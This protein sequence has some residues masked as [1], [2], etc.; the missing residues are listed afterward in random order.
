MA[1][2]ALR[3]AKKGKDMSVCSLYMKMQHVLVK[4]L[5]QKFVMKIWLNGTKK[6][7]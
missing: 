4:R 7:L 6:Y 2:K 3:D 1:K 5:P